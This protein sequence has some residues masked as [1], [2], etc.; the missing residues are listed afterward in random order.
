MFQSAAKFAGPGTQ[1]QFY[2][3]R[4]MD[5]LGTARGRLGVL[6]APSLMIYATAGLAMG[7]FRFTDSV[8]YPLGGVPMQTRSDNAVRSGLVFGAG[9]E[10][11]I[12]K[13]WSVKGEYLEYRFGSS[14][15]S[16]PQFPGFQVNYTTTSKNNGSLL[17]GGVNYKF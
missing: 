3:S 8:G 14:R 17:R 7:G 10:Y 11:A 13:N 9:V 4:S 15:V 12:N 1:G 6:A 2:T 5:W 16:I